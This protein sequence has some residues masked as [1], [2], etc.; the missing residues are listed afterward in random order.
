MEHNWIHKT[1]FVS[2]VV[3]E[4]AL[5]LEKGADIQRTTTVS[6]KT[7]TET[8]KSG[9]PVPVFLTCT[10]F[11]CDHNINTVLHFRFKFSCFLLLV[12]SQ[13]I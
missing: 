11:R 2:L 1:L 9:R 5:L 12:V 3:V 10:S 13:Q 4:R 6:G 7:A 8:Y